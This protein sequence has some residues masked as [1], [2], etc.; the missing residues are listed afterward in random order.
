MH[1]QYASFPLLLFRLLYPGQ[2][3]PVCIFCI[4]H[5]IHKTPPLSPDQKDIR[6]SCRM[7]QDNHFFHMPEAFL[8]DPPILLPSQNPPA[9]H[10]P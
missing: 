5:S 7:L 10:L 3:N 8:K 1:W 2:Q 9:Q 4:T 6:L